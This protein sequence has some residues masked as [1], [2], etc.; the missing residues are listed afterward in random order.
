[1]EIYFSELD[2][3][4]QKALLNEFDLDDSQEVGW[5]KIPIAEIDMMNNPELEKDTV[6]K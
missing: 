6:K 3:A 5:D 1:M 4:T 2:K